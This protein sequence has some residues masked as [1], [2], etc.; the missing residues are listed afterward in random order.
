MK[1]RL[2]QWMFGRYG[3]DQLGRIL[4]IVAM[5]LLTLG[6]FLSDVLVTVAFVL[7]I[8]Q[9]FRMFSRNIGN[10]SRENLVY[11]SWHRRFVGRFKSAQM[12]AQQRRTHRF[13]R[14]PSCNQQ[15]RVPKGKG[16]INIT[17][18]GCKTQFKR[19]S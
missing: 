4:N 9:N 19:K 11:I 17:C 15:L 16:E 14:C 12:Q 5:I 18:P 8:Y 10:R 2:R 3:M 6:I 7:I 13:Y 1:E